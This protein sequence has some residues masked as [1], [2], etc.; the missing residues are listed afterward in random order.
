MKDKKKRRKERQRCPCPR[1]VSYEKQ[2]FRGNG[3]PKWM[4]NYGYFEKK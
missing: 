2:I 1:I 3:L 4:G